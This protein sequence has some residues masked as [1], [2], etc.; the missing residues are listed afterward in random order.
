MY[1]V[2]WVS[3]FP[4]VKTQTAFCP[5][6]CQYSLSDSLPFVRKGVVKIWK[7]PQTRETKQ[8]QEA[9]FYVFLIVILANIGK[10]KFSYK[11]LIFN[12]FTFISFLLVIEPFSRTK[13]FLTSCS[14]LFIA[15]SW[16]CYVNIRHKWLIINT[17]LFWE[18][19]WCSQI[20]PTAL[21]GKN[22]V[23]VVSTK[24]PNFVQIRW[25]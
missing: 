1:S 22:H 20:V 16:L 19:M 12:V 21:T 9:V 14:S 11:A 15:I 10:Y 4:A 2:H 23:K 17:S 8:K 6:I 3:A 5:F 25:F 18:Q 24:V 7:I 13:I